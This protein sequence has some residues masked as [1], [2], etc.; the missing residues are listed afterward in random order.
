MK[1]GS[2]CNRCRLKL[3]RNNPTIFEDCRYWLTWRT[4]KRAVFIGS[5]ARRLLRPGKLSLEIFVI[6]M[7]T[8]HIL[9]CQILVQSMTLKECLCF[10]SFFFLDF[11]MLSIPKICWSTLG[12]CLFFYFYFI[13]RLSN[14]LLKL[15]VRMFWSKFYFPLLFKI[16]IPYLIVGCI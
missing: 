11:P 7:Q 2:Y 1:D 12:N 15:F 9:L 16:R 13:L 5:R 10:C 14:L 3:T 8:Q 6:F 4:E